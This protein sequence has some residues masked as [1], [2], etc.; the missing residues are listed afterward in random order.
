ML[1]VCWQV[2]NYST[3]ISILN[4]VSTF[5]RCVGIAHIAMHLHIYP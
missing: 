5:P 2:G 4:P 3:P 1:H